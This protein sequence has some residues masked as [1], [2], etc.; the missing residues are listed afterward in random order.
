M[1]YRDKVLSRKELD[2]LVRRWEGG[3]IIDTK[4][5]IRELIKV[6][7]ACEAERRRDSVI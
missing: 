4:L 2:I 6:F 3:D 5:L 7:R 1:N